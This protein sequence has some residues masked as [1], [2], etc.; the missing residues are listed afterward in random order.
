MDV[1]TSSQAVEI[2]SGTRGVFASVGIHPW[3]AAEKFPDNSREKL[4]I[5]A[6]TAVNVAIGEVGLDFIDNVF[7]GITYHDN[8]YLRHEQEYAFRMQVELACE[9]KLP[10][11]IHARGAYS[12]LI[13]ILKDEG[14]NRV[15]GVIHNFDEDNS[16]ARTLMDMGFFLSFGGALTY[17][18][19]E[20]LRGTVRHIPLDRILIETDSPYMP[21]YKRESER[22]EPANVAFVVGVLA[23]LKQIDADDLINTTCKNFATLFN[24]ES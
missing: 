1:E 16:T 5:L 6:Q 13:S 9:L 8:E 23:E 10:L 3:I 22:N 19:A 17:P 20:K 18:T 21:L 12:R 4:S 7:A 15:G 11:I 14:A 2:A 24:I